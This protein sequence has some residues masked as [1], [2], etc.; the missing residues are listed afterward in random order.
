[1]AH[2][3][4]SAY[5][6]LL[7][8]AQRAPSRSAICFRCERHTALKGILGQKSLQSS[9]VF[10]NEHWENEDWLHSIKEPSQTNIR[11]RHKRKTCLTSPNWVTD[12]QCAVDVF[13]SKARIEWCYP[14]N[15][16]MEYSATSIQRTRSSSLWK[17]HYTTFFL[18]MSQL[19][20]L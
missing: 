7:T 9:L 17:H 11:F 1:M 3:A 16:R 6:T 14:R 2:R 4:H 20:I 12:E 8:T 5:T 18:A 19:Y 15:R 13:Y 10:K